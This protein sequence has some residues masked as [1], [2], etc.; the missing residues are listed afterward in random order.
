MHNCVV[1]F[2]HMDDQKIRTLIVCMYLSI[3]HLPPLTLKLC[4]SISAKKSITQL[5][6]R[7]TLMSAEIASV[8]NKKMHI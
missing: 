3:V 7:M 6:Q 2:Q 1:R 4:L 8:E 5:Q